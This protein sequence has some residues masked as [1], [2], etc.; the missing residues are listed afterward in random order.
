LGE[1]VRGA[2]RA[3]VGCDLASVHLT[4]ED[5]DRCA[6]RFGQN[7]RRGPAFID[8]IPAEKRAYYDAV[9][10]AYQ[11]MNDPRTPVPTGIGGQYQTWGRL[12]GVGCSL[13]P[14]FKRGA[15]FSDR[16]KATGAI[17]VPLGPIS[18]G[19]VLPQGSWTPELAIAPP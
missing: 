10:S 16:V 14:K 8:P 7:A 3:G 19:V 13:T 18:C 11:A 12:P 6:E 1:G 17:A 5:K 15:S 2:L 9:Q 4:P